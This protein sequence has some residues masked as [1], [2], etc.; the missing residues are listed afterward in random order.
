MLTE[1]QI[2]MMSILNARFLTR[3]YKYI[4]KMEK[5]N[6]GDGVLFNLIHTALKF[7]LFK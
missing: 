4:V 3:S 7:L 6:V 5:Y 2:V 1:R